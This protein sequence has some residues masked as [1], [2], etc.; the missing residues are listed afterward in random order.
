ML[1]QHHLAI[2]VCICTLS[3]HQCAVIHAGALCHHQ[4]QALMPPLR[5][6]D[7]RMRSVIPSSAVGPRMATW[8]HS[9]TCLASA[10]CLVW[11]WDIGAIGHYPYWIIVL[12]SAP[13]LDGALSA[14]RQQEAVCDAIQ[15]CQAQDGVLVAER[16]LPCK[17]CLLCLGWW[18]RLQ[19]RPI[20]SGIIAG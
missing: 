9:A 20:T 11:D 3:S 10:A 4:R 17:R 12:E 14:T 19:T 8:W 1:A 5:L 18:H 7:N 13:G 2:N 6:H 16:G 15:R